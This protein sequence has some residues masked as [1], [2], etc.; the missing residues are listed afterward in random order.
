MMML[1]CGLKEGLPAGTT[2]ALAAYALAAGA[3]LLSLLLCHA[4]AKQVAYAHG[5]NSFL[6]LVSLAAIPEPAL[7][8]LLGTGLLSAHLALR[9][10]RR[11]PNSRID[12]IHERR[13]TF[14]GGQHDLVH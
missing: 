4:D 7:L 14:A 11:P 9:R 5:A 1:R 6:D 13:P 12:Q 2:Y 3:L 10:R 8:A